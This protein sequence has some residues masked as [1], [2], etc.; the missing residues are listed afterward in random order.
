MRAGNFGATSRLQSPDEADQSRA[1]LFSSTAA[2]VVGLIM[3]V[4]GDKHGGLLAAANIKYLNP[5]LFHRISSDCDEV[6]M[7][8][9]A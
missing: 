9:L 3:V 4:I 6:E 2:V 7:G 8:L 5:A 1:V